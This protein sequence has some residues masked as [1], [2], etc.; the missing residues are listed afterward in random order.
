VLYHNAEGKVWGANTA[1]TSLYLTGEHARKYQYTLEDYTS[2]TVTLATVADSSD[3]TKL[4]S[5]SRFWVASDASKYLVSS[6]GYYTTAAPD[7]FNSDVA[8]FFVDGGP[9][10]SGTE[11]TDYL[12]YCSAGGLV[13][14]HR[15]GSK[16]ACYGRDASASD[17]WVIVVDSSTESVSWAVRWNPPSESVTSADYP[18]DMQFLSSGELLACGPSVPLQQNFTVAT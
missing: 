2:N 9:G 3:A 11:F 1:F 4:L 15:S 13:P 5:L 18:R 16:L 8:M 12:T 7:T 17:S 10:F 14:M 6:S